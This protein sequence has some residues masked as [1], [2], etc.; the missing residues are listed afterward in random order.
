[1][2]KFYVD[3][4]ADMFDPELR[5]N[6][7]FLAPSKIKLKGKALNFDGYGNNYDEIV[8]NVK[9]SAYTLE[10]LTDKEW[11]KFFEEQLSD[12]S[13]IVYFAPAFRL[14]HDGAESIKKVFS[15]LQEEHPAQKVILLDTHTISR[16]I[17]EIAANTHR[18]YIK[19]ND[20]D[21]ALQFANSMIEKYVSLLAVDNATTLKNSPIMGTAM[22]NFAGASLN[23]KPIICADT[24]CK[25]KVLDKDKT[26]K[27][28]VAK[29]Y[30]NTKL[31]GLNIADYTFSIVH[32]NAEKEATALYERFRK[33]V[34]PNE[35]RLVKMSLNNA[36]VVGCKCVGI[37]FHS[38]Y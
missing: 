16:G 30:S 10:F 25:F 20:L 19:E 29:L 36:I 32:F 26:F 34:G 2:I 21:I 28:A 4:Y 24:N 27:N 23:L 22:K 37:T 9:S 33:I 12:G 18:I 35:I 11:K 13:D 1:M 8:Q 17:S 31:N 14:W 7:L 6:G 15:T 3:A 5:Q 38:K